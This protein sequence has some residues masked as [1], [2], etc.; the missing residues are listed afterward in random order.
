MMYLSRHD[1]IAT[2]PGVALIKDCEE[3]EISLGFGCDRDVSLCGA[4][5]HPPN[6]SDISRIYEVL[7]RGAD[8]AQDGGAQ[9]VLLRVALCSAPRADHP[10]QPYY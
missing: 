2:E 1:L 8:A 9:G 4:A 5:S 6:V 7:A 3:R 10:L